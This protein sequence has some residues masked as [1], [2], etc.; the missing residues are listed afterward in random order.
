VL[1]YVENPWGVH[2]LAQTCFGNLAVVF[3]TVR[4]VVSR[5]MVTLEYALVIRQYLEKDSRRSEIG[6]LEIHSNLAA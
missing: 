3:S 2:G 6:N 1:F 5:Y 4:T